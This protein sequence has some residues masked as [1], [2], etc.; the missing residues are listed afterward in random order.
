MQTDHGVTSVQVRLF[1]TGAK[2]PTERHWSEFLVD[3]ADPAAAAAADIPDGWEQRTTAAGIVYFVDHVHR[4]TTVGADV[5]VSL[6]VL[7]GGFVAFSVRGCV[8]LP[9]F[10]ARSRSLSPVCFV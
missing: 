10:L 9:L 5:A 4:R 1:A 6:V 8:F 3:E 2:D 7:G